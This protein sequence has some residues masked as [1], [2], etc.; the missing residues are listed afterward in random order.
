MP[1]LPGRESVKLK[2]PLE[3]LVIASFFMPWEGRYAKRECIVEGCDH[4]IEDCYVANRQPGI[5]VEE[6]QYDRD[7]KDGTMRARSGPVCEHC[8]D[9]ILAQG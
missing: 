1:K 6:K 2:I 5:A 4:R 7:L 3:K 8:T 9:A